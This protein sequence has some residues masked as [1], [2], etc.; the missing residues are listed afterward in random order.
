MVTRKKKD[1]KA[2]DDILL[3]TDAKKIIKKKSKP[4]KPATQPR[5]VKGNHL[6]VTT[7]ED[8]RTELVWDDAVLLKEVQDAILQYELSQ[9]KPAVRAKSTARLKRVK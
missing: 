8:G 9:K 2:E 3:A 6:T 4:V 5:V 1:I 7:Y